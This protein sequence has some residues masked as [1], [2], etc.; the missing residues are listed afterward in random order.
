MLCVADF[1]AALLRKNGEKRKKMAQDQ[2]DQAVHDHVPHYPQPLEKHLLADLA[3]LFRPRLENKKVDQQPHRDG[4][5]KFQPGPEVGFKK[6]AL[7]EDRGEADELKL[8]LM[9]Y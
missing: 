6:V 9:I 1:S 2:K 7:G 8:T 3:C 5:D 4:Q